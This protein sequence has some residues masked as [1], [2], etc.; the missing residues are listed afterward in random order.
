[1]LNIF[2]GFKRPY[3]T[4]PAELALTDTLFSVLVMSTKD[5]STIW[6]SLASTTIKSLDEDISAYNYVNSG[7]KVD[8][9]SYAAI[10]SILAVTATPAD[11]KE[12]G[13]GAF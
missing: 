5:S 4:Y 13:T 11:I 6:C 8:I 9:T 1:M 10:S 3:S 2:N 7:T 12:P